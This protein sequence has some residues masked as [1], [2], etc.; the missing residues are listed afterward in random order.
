MTLVEEIVRAIKQGHIRYKMIPL[1]KSFK[2]KKNLQLLYKG[3][4]I[5]TVCKL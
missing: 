3:H 2:V 5:S 1:L 4:E